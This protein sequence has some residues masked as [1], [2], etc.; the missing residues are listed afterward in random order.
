MRSR[1]ARVAAM[2]A[3]IVVSSAAVA[4]GLVLA[5]GS[6]FTAAAH[7]LR[8][9]RRHAAR[10]RRSGTLHAAQVLERLAGEFQGKTLGLRSTTTISGPVNAGAA[11][12]NSPAAPAPA[13]AQAPAPTPA[14]SHV[15]DARTFTDATSTT[16]PNWAC[17]RAQESGDN[18]S[19]NTGNGYSGAYQFL[20]STWN[21]AVSA[22]GFPQY[23]NG[24]AFEA[25]PAVQNAA[26]LWLYNRDG[27]QP[28]STRYVCGL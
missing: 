7:S 9:H 25:P 21:E 15:V 1:I 18:Y 17:I 8:R 16:T 27:W 5:G 20:P 13:P 10:P 2:I 11:P 28:W 6:S 23:A 14:P 4:G 26:A 24:W 19:E 22:A 3:V 12:A